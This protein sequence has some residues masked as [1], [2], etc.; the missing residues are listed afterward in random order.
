VSTHVWPPSLD[1]LKQDMNIPL[2]NNEDDLNLTSDLAASV[3]YVQRVRPTFNYTGDLDSC[4]PAPTDDLWSGTVA[5][6]RR[7]N[8]RRR[9]PDGMV[10]SADMGSTRVTSVDRDIDRLLGIGSFQAPVIA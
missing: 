3:A 5:Y 10:S 9:S 8:S 6:A 7:L 1:D 4:D 2:D